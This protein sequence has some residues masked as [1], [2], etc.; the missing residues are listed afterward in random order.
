MVTTGRAHCIHNC[1]YIYIYIVS[2]VGGISVLPHLT[3]IYYI[4]IYIYICGFNSF[5]ILFSAPGS[6][7]PGSPVFPAPRE[8]AFPNSNSIWIQWTNS[9]S[10]GMILLIPN[11]FIYLLILNLPISLISV[12][13]LCLRVSSHP[14]QSLSNL[15]LSQSIARERERGSRREMSLLDWVFLW[16][17]LEE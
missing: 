11:F 17:Q 14:G 5:F 4:Y 10:V 9:H 16:H 8:P 6:F 15:L 7:S 12:I 13:P 1:I 2:K 3:V